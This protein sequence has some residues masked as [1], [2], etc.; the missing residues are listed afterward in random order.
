[1]AGGANL[2]GFAGG[3][4]VNYSDPFGL[5]PQGYIEAPNGTCFNEGAVMLM[6]V[7][8]AVAE[9]ASSFRA[10]VAGARTLEDATA[11]SGGMSAGPMQAMERQFASAGRKAVEKTIKSL[12]GRIA[13]H[14]E[15]IAEAASQGGK[16]NSMEREVNAW[17]ETIKAGIRVLEK[18]KQ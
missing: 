11:A 9:V 14:E 15:K 4:R 12:T 16:T 8:G 7:G 5:C 10:F 17:K 2:Y 13:E 3:D 18:N 1:L 6:A